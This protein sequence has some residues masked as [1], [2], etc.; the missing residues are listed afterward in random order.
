LAARACSWLS[1]LVAW[2]AI[3]PKKCLTRSAWADFATAAATITAFIA[4]HNTHHAHPFTWKKGIR[5][6]QHLEDKLAEAAAAPALDLGQL[7]TG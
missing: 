2:F 3:L 1:F 6:Y 4:T 5:F 7:A